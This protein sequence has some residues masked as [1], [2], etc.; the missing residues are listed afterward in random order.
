[1]NV[2][3]L[4]LMIIAAVLFAIGAVGRR[5]TTAQDGGGWYTHATFVNAGLFFL[6]VGLILQFAAKSHT[7]T[8]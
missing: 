3:S 8:F 6:T 5:G 1:M 2:I 7:I 4:V